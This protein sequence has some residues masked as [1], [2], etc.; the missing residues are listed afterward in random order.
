MRVRRSGQGEQEN[1]ATARCRIKGEGR[2]GAL[3]SEAT[4]AELA[5]KYQL[6]PNQ[7]YAWQKQLLEGATAIFGGGAGKDRNH[8]AELGELYATSL[9]G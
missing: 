5:A 6:H 4:V 7:I 3:R 1:Q 9:S 8:E 2:A